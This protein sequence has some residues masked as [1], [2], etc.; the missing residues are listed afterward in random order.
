MMRANG[1]TPFKKYLIN[2]ANRGSKEAMFERLV[3]LNFFQAP[4]GVPPA[5]TGFKKSLLMLT[6]DQVSESSESA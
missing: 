1:D 3:D 6:P 5:S 4:P 2:S